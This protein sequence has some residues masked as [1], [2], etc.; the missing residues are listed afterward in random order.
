MTDG[1]QIIPDPKDSRK[2]EMR[3]TFEEK[4][5]VFACNKLN[6]AGVLFFFFFEHQQ[7]SFLMHKHGRANS[8]AAHA[9]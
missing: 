8:T 9:C 7:G 2:T 1:N 5:V 6:I 3:L 4:P